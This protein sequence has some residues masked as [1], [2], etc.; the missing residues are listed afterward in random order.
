MKTKILILIM[1]LF[2]FGLVAFPVI[3]Q[4]QGVTSFNGIH[5]SQSSFGTATPQL[6]IDS[7]STNAILEVRD[8]ATPVFRIPDGG[9]LN[10]LSGSLTS[11]GI[12]NLADTDSV[13]TGA[14]TIT[15]TYSYLQVS[16]SAVLT[17]TLATGSATDGDILIIHNLVSTTTTVIDT[18]ATQGG[19]NVTLGQDDPAIFIFGDGVWVE[20][21]S[22]DNS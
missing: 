18:G 20:I 1:A 3:G 6:L 21:A 9:G 13:L 15:P 5:L 11:D 10:I 14:Q 16:P 19:G 8:S 4:L 7:S 12:L 17:L 22:P 2:I